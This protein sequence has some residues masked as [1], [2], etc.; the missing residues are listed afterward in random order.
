MSLPPTFAFVGLEPEAELSCFLGGLSLRCLMSARLPASFFRSCLSPQPLVLVLLSPPA[1]ADPPVFSPFVQTRG[2]SP[3][4]MALASTGGE[5]IPRP[6]RLDRDSSKYFAAL[7]LRGPAAAPPPATLKP[8]AA[9]PYDMQ[10][11]LWRSDAPQLVAVH[12][13]RPY[14][15]K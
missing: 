5:R 15:V 2:V 4:A 13:V 1:S 9:L 8:L 11:F 3:P 14:S 10:P 12:P 7:D 6:G